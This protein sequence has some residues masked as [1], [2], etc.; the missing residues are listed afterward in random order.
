MDLLI[1][2]AKRIDRAEF[3]ED[4]NICINGVWY[5]ESYNCDSSDLAEIIIKC[6]KGEAI[7]EDIVK[8][9]SDETH[10]DKIL[11]Y[12]DSDENYLIKIKS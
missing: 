1:D 11:R 2:Y 10:F 6:E 4:W 3:K 5:S 9:N 12:K 8:Y 7:I